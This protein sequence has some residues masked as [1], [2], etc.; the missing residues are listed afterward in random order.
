[1]N[2]KTNPNKNTARLTM[3]IN[4]WQINSLER[5]R[6]LGPDD[7]NGLLDE[8][9]LKRFFAAWGAYFECRHPQEPHLVWGQ[10]ISY[11][12]GAFVNPKALYAH[13]LSA[14]VVADQLVKRSNRKP[15]CV[16]GP[17]YGAWGLVP[18]LAQRYGGIRQWLTCSA[19]VRKEQV[20]LGPALAG[21]SNVQLCDD[22]IRGGE[23]LKELILSVEASN[24][25]VIINDQ[26][27]TI[28]NLSG[29]AKLGQFQI[30]SLMSFTEQGWLPQDCP[31]CKQGSQMVRE[32]RPYLYQPFSK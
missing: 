26:I 6:E 13:P 14:A 31:L 23:T 20:W 27:L 29:Q 22:V 5:L 25:G 18:A 30:I 9:E 16:V 10:T 11:H 17:S 24:P 8:Y 4:I 2:T 7:L 19:G 1:V 21:G 32:I 3:M 28:V 12:Y 15:D